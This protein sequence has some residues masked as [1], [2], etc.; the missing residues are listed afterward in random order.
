MSTLLSI[1]VGDRC[2]GRCDA[3]CYDAKD[4]NCDCVCGGMN[5][6]AGEQQAKTNTRDFWI[7]WTDDYSKKKGLTRFTARVNPAALQISLFETSA[8]AETILT[9]G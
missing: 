5:H 8:F 6:G 2:I 4:T 1:N 7:E 3:R 9:Q